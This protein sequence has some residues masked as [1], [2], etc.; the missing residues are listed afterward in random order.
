MR[1]TM[2]DRPRKYK[3]ASDRVLA[4]ARRMMKSELLSGR[5]DPEGL[6]ALVR[7]V[8]PG[9]DIGDPRFLS[10]LY[11]LNPRGPAIEFMA[12]SGDS[13][14]GHIAVLPQRYKVGQ[15]AVYGGVVV[16]AITHPDFR[17]RGIFMVLHEELFQSPPA[18][19]IA[20]SF[21]F[22]N[23]NS[24][25]G[26][27]RH[28]GYQELGRLPFWILPFNLPRILAAQASRKGAAWRAAAR[29][30]QPFVKLWST[31]RRPRG[32]GSIA[33]ENVKELGPEFDD[34]WPA[35]SA[36]TENI[37]V[38]DRAFLDWRFIRSPTRRYDVFAARKN[39][40]LV[41]YLVGHSTVMEGLRW[42]IIMDLLSEDSPAGRAAT[43]RLVA[44]YG[45]HMMRAGVDIAACLMFK[46]A[47]AARGLRRNGYIVCPPAL[48][49][50]EFPA[51]LRWYGPSSPPARFF[52]P[53]SW[54]LTLA[55]YDAI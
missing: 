38:R 27:F 2:A 49:P 45:R 9:E 21:G 41:G 40:R 39:G 31:A 54:F 20:F 10:W 50:R 46:H 30:A 8:F 12:K 29:A 7:T 26:C 34:L 24:E 28:L 47:P 44:A 36:G 3:L 5:P 4:R 23:L 16:N 14:T 22:A 37:L 17:G 25:K 18:K 43:D 53:K 13:V 32:P 15:D 6:L 55:D 11:D 42:G 52:D 35:A 33:V 1:M 51:L 48:L 19:G